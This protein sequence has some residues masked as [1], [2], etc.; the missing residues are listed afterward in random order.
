MEEEEKP[1]WYYASPQSEDIKVQ[2]SDLTLE[3]TEYKI[4]PRVID[5]AATNPFRGLKT[6]NPYRHIECFTML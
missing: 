3:A 5:M 2:K 1:L 4:E 6:D